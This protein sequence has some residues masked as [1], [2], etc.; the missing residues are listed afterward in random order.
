M[1]TVYKLYI[2]LYAYRKEKI[3][4]IERGKIG[5]EINLIF[6]GFYTSHT[7]MQLHIHIL[8]YLFS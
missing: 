5:Q 7:Q 6:N 3:E 8:V 2:L 1:Q 4:E